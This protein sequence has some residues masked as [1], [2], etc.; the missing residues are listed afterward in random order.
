MSMHGER[1]RRQAYVGDELVETVLKAA[2]EPLG[3]YEIRDRIV[4]GGTRISVPQVYRVLARLV[5][6]ARVRRIETL[7]A[8]AVGG[9]PSD[10]LAICRTCQSATPVPV[11]D[12]GHQTAA[13]A[14]TTGFRCE[15]LVIELV[16]TC[17]ACR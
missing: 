1:R 3:A 4:A 12:L 5:V 9:A 13:L 2:C 10:A 17:V 8:Y 15:R 6:Q 14:E 11:G 16:G 7:N